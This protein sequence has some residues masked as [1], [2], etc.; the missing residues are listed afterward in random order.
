MR[1]TPSNNA[2]RA[3]F[4]LIEMLVIA[5]IVLITIAVFIGIIINLTGETMV[6]R[7]SNSLAYDVQETLNA[8]E[9]D[10]ALSG[11]FLAIN[12]V[13]VASPQ[14]YNDT[15]QGFVNASTDRGAMLILNVAA[16]YSA[17]EWNN[18]S[19]VLLDNSPHSCASDLVN[20]NQALTYNIIYFVKDNTLWRRTLMPS[21]YA[22]A[23]CVPPIQEPSCAPGITGGMCR[24]SDRKLISGITTAGFALQ[25]FSSAQSTLPVADAGD[26]TATVTDRQ[27]ALTTTD[28][29]TVTI[30]ATRD[31]AGKAANYTG[32][33]RVTRI[34]PLNEEVTLVP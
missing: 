3:G 9:Q 33:L 14:G 18:R 30:N 12:S 11:A 4:T 6:A 15:T 22:T 20:Q 21:T 13:S 26:A 7:T 10:V 25:Y 1:C 19:V 27:N 29:T 17:S 31:V 16:T 5:P 8:I 23:G 2:V 24:T 34:G 32:S 28:T